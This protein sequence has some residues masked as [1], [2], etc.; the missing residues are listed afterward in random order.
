MNGRNHTFGQKGTTLVE[1]M[2]ALTI[3]SIVVVFIGGLLT[4]SAA[5]GRANAAAQDAADQGYNLLLTFRKNF[6]TKTPGNDRSCGALGLPPPPSSAYCTASCQAGKQNCLKI[7]TRRGMTGDY[8]DT[9]F[10]TLCE[11]RPTV[12]ASLV[13]TS[14][15][16]FPSRCRPPVNVCS[17]NQRPYVLVTA[18]RFTGGVEVQRRVSRFPPTG[19]GGGTVAT[20]VGAEFCLSINDSVAVPDGSADVN[21]RTFFLGNGRAERQPVFKD[22]ISQTLEETAIENSDIIVLP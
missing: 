18:V 13:T 22:D 4:Q 2:I 5:D 3:M 17:A 9:T 7:V 11:A 15:Y 10:E 6:L 16:R 14:S 8:Q 1:L 12:L 21:I 20:T 19:T